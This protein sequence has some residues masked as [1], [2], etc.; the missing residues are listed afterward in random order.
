[1]PKCQKN[2]AHIL[3][4]SRVI[5]RMKD[6]ESANSTTLGQTLYSQ[7]RRCLGYLAPPVQRSGLARK[8]KAEIKQ[9]SKEVK[10]TAERDD[11]TRALESQRDA[12][13]PTR[14]IHRPTFIRQPK[15]IGKSV[16][17]AAVQAMAASRKR[18]S[19]T[20]LKTQSARSSISERGSSKTEGAESITTLGN[21][22]E[23]EKAS[24]RETSRSTISTD[25]EVERLR[26]D[27]QAKGGPLH[28]TRFGTT[29]Q[30]LQ[31]IQISWFLSERRPV[32]AEVR[33]M[34]LQNALPLFSNS[35][36]IMPYTRLLS[37]DFAPH[38]AEF[39]LSYTNKVGQSIV[40]PTLSNS[41]LEKGTSCQY[42]MVSLK[43]AKVATFI[44][45]RLTVQKAE[46]RGRGFVA[47]VDAWV[48]F[49]PRADGKKITSRKRGRK[50]RERKCMI[51]D[52]KVAKIQVS[53]KDQ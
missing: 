26:A 31:L 1:M 21:M 30:S 23:K 39:V 47:Y 33:E 49:L 34:L 43:N 42:L 3:N 22:K 25:S 36:E 35:C 28:G 40:L 32:S 38:L 46:Q 2:F 50:R 44:V 51:I 24:G 27:I 18:A 9:P 10:T 6:L 8:T 7:Q 5:A 52:E 17:G 15:L 41:T 53:F 29:R 4:M 16:E 48:F 37:E 45:I 11:L 19:A 13:R 20:R 14:R 12:S